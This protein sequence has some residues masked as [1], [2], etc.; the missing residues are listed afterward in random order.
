MCQTNQPIPV[1]QTTTVF[2][3]RALSLPPPS[4][5][6]EF[7]LQFFSLCFEVFSI[8]FS[9]RGFVNPESS[10]RSPLLGHDEV[11]LFLPGS[12]LRLSGFCL[13]RTVHCVLP[14]FISS[15]GF[16]LNF[17][18]RPWEGSFFPSSGQPSVGPYSCSFAR[19]GT[20]FLLPG[21]LK[22]ASKLGSRLSHFLHSS[23][24]AS[25]LLS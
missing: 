20:R 11:P 14:P 21:N 17:F 25:P 2:P 10:S 16:G 9:A 12:P 19:I 22:S 13:W 7:V 6:C 15:S 24:P 4:A 8:P 23:L 18:S 5:V 1:P 3:P